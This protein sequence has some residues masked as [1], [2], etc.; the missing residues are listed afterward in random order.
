MKENYRPASILP[1]LSKI[2]EKNL[3]KQI[4]DYFEGIFDKHHCGFRK[5]YNTQQCL[6]K[7]LEKWKSSVDKG[8]DFDV[9]LTNLPKAFEFLDHELPIAKLDAYGFS[10]LAAILIHDY[11]SNR[12]QK[13]RTGNSYSSWF[14]IV[15]GVH[16]DQYWDHFH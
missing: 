13:T 6:L 2:F 7:L 1:F 16:E 12:K 9:L 8:R 15:F 14:E 10:L 5:G 4:S 3:F 11:L